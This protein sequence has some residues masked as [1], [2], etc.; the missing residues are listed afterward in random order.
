MKRTLRY[1]LCA[2][3]ATGVATAQNLVFHNTLGSAAEAATSVVGPGLTPQTGADG[4][5]V[6]ANPVF[7]AGFDGGAVSLGGVQPPYGYTTFGRNRLYGLSNAANVVNAD[8][9]TAEAVFRLV[10]PPGVPGAFWNYLH[11][12]DG[13]YEENPNSKF[14]FSVGGYLQPS[15][16]YAGIRVY[17]SIRSDDMPVTAAAPMSLT[18]GLPGADIAGQVGMWIKATAVWDRY[19]IDGTWD[20]MRIYVNGVLA[21][22]TVNDHWTTQVGPSFDIGGSAAFAQ[23]A[24]FYDDLKIWDAPMIPTSGPMA[25]SFVTGAAA[26]AVTNC[27]GEPG[28]FGL[29]A[30]SFDPENGGPNA[31]TGWMAGL[32]IAPSDLLAQ[33]TSFAAPFVFTF[34]GYGSFCFDVPPPVAAFLAGQTIYGVTLAVDPTTMGIRS[35]APCAHFHL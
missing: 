2:L 26:P 21:A 19:G 25:L 16:G 13:P 7:G 9:G 33:W 6:V 31:G 34:D 11:L 14:L 17:F 15:G 1:G 5:Y 28:D 22:K 4:L 10:T 29:T 12:I 20:S 32:F 27:F 3:V 35:I 8:R 18:D 23:G 24:Y 30:L